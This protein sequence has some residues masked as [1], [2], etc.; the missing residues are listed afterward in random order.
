MRTHFK[1]QANHSLSQTVSHHPD[2]GNILDKPQIYLN[3]IS[4]ISQPYLSHISAI[5]Q[6]CL[7]ISQPYLRHISAKTPT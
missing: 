2:C 6:P 7:S 1:T 4:T 5:S 3:Y